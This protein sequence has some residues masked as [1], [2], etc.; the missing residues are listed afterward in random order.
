MSIK[1]SWAQ[2]KAQETISQ[3]LLASGPCVPLGH[4]RTSIMSPEKNTNEHID[5]ID[6]LRYETNKGGR[7]ME[8]AIASLRADPLYAPFVDGALSMAEE[9]N[10]SLD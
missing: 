3:Y 8:D 7:T 4:A 2:L 1:L 5:I 6:Y 10:L 9:L